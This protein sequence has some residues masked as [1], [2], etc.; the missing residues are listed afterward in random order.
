MLINELL[1]LHSWQRSRFD[2]P[3]NK[4]VPG[5]RRYTAEL[6]DLQL[7]YTAT[8]KPNANRTGV[9]HEAMHAAVEEATRSA[10]GFRQ[11]SQVA[12]SDRPNKQ[13]GYAPAISTFD[14]ELFH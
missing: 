2:P 3:F 10:T 8:K 5:P 12:W 4:H 13:C 11:Q 9:R 1:C 14:G 7:A 6:E